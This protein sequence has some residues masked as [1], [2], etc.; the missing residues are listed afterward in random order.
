MIKQLIN[1]A[2]EY[3]LAHEEARDLWATVRYDSDDKA[4]R[5]RYRSWRIAHGFTF[6]NWGL[7][8]NVET[9]RESPMWPAWVIVGLH[10]GPWSIFVQR[11]VGKL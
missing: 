4:A 1:R 2:F 5:S 6:T 7:G 9:Q 3:D 11:E 8:P 10:L